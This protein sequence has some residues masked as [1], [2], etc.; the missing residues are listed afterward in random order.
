MRTFNK[1]YGISLLSILLSVAACTSETEE[2][3]DKPLPDPEGGGT[4]RREVLLT[5]KNKLSVVQTKAGDVIATADENKIS[6]LDIYVFGSTTE[7]GTYSYQER[8]C[9]R[10]K[11]ADM[12][13][14]NDVT[15]LDLTA[16]DA[17][18]K[19][20]TALLSLKKGLFVKLYCIANQP[21]L[22]DADGNIVTNFVALQQS[23]P[24]QA[25]NTVTEGSPLETAFL[26]YHSP[27][28]DAWSNTDILLTPLPMT[29]AY[30]TPLDL[31]D[32]SVSARLQ[33]GLTRSVARFDIVNDAALSKFTIQSVSMA[34]GRQG[35]SFFPLKVY[36]SQP[37]ADGELITYPA[38]KFEGDKANEGNCIG[39]FYSWP[40]P[41]GDGGNLILSGTYAANL[42][43]PVPVTYK[44]F[45]KPESDGN[46]IEVSQ[47][48]RYTVNITKADEYHL[49]FT[50][51]VED[52]TDEGNIDDY[53][54]GGD[55]DADGLTFANTGTGDADYD[56]VT[57]TVT[58]GLTGTEQFTLTG[59]STSGYFVTLY[60]ENGDKDNQWLDITP[61]P[62]YMPT[63]AD[64]DSKIE[65]TIK[66][67]S[68]YI[69]KYPVATFRF[70]DKITAKESIVM[71]QPLAKP[72]VKQVSVS[73]GSSIDVEN[74][75]ITFHQNTDAV[76]PE[77]TFNVFA[78]GGSKLLFG[79]SDAETPEDW[80][81]VTQ[82]QT[83]YTLKVNT[84]DPSFT[85]DIFTNGAKI[86]ILN[87]GNESM[88]EEFVLIFKSDFAV[89]SK[90]TSSGSTFDKLNKIIMFSQTTG[91]T[92]PNVTFNVFA[93]GGSK[94]E[95]PDNNVT[96]NWLTIDPTGKELNQIQGD[97]KLT[98]NMTGTG[99]PDPYSTDGIK[100]NIVNK[101]N[102]TQTEAYTLKMT[103]NNPE[104]ASAQ[105]TSSASSGSLSYYDTTNKTIH[106]FNDASSVK[107]TVF[108]IG[109]CIVNNEDK[110][111]WVTVTS[112]ST[113][114][115]MILTFSQ[116]SLNQNATGTLKIRN[117]LDE[118]KY[119]ELKVN[120]RNKNVTFESTN[121]T[122]SN[123]P[124]TA[125]VNAFSTSDPKI[126]YYPTTS[127]NFT[128]QVRSPKG[129]SLNISESKNLIGNGAISQWINAAVSGTSTASN[130]DVLNTIKVTMGSTSTSIMNIDRK[131][132]RLTTQNNVS[133]CANKV[134]TVITEAP[135]YPGVAGQAP[136]SITT[137]R[138]DW[139]VAPMSVNGGRA[140]NSSTF[141]SIRTSCCPS[142]WYL[143][144]SYDFNYV[145]SNNVGPVNNTYYQYSNTTIR[146]VARAAFTESRYFVNEV[147]PTSSDESVWYN[148]FSPNL[149][150]W[151]GYSNLYN[152]GGLYK[153]NAYARCVKNI[154]Y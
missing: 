90:V 65:Y 89:T 118:N 114:N 129:V 50:I 76:I 66:L 26:T 43:D 39:A 8:F 71:V 142:G 84:L 2:R 46:Y 101:G 16:K 81:T 31:T 127:D 132:C 78:S 28:L 86:K 112:G 13:V 120:N 56:A 98:V 126:K 54:P 91:I 107:L 135:T 67:A 143:P 148:I 100:M 36:G 57:R 115:T 58:M 61:A 94:I 146:D 10:E 44:V 32:F 130:G 9:Y 131:S 140:M 25:T 12:P 106:L 68:P 53:E 24:G 105:P 121:I 42:T 7:N 125:I 30:T 37:A 150:G 1:L 109:G 49:D 38:R 77:V 149:D 141:N 152:L 128:F 64:V 96:G 23:T 74:K 151:A 147:Q 82:S 20:T 75:K 93:F 144:T 117:K 153:D 3:H 59:A 33:L 45:F 40:S 136:K 11:A 103:I 134:V 70:T 97:Y 60:Y 34:N 14:G 123:A 5:L 88:V 92:T 4:A 41:M 111:S 6:S 85:E 63:K 108:S 138:Q 19:E 21:K 15:A 104:L 35:V 139:W 124:S 52:W 102:A 18:G 83:N 110:P 69:G 95:F 29:G 133:G 154:S 145:F 73:S 99:F 122:A 80:L 48:H 79:D 17:D 87:V 62:D 116:N 137:A 51:N 113:T 22:L 119:I 72:V 47:N 55:V 27:L